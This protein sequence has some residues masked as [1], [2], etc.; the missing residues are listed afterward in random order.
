MKLNPTKAYIEGKRVIV[1][2]DSIVRGTTSRKIVEMIRRAGAT[3]VH[4][5]I[6]SPPITH[7]C[8]F[9]IDMPTHEELIA[10]SKTVE[11]TRE[12]ITADSLAYLSLEGLL[13]CVAP[14]SEDFCSSCFTGNYPIAVE[15]NDPQLSLFRELRTSEHRV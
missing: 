4:M 9:G 2:D 8:F 3:E 10:S 13:R 5:R 7:P 6:S 12:F 1:V 11:E 15:S 14:R